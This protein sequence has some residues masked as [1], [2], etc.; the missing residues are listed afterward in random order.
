MEDRP[1][2]T[3]KIERIGVRCAILLTSGADTPIDQ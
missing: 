2:R 3:R 1:A